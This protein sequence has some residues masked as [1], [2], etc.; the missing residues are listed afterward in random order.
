MRR[1]SAFTI[2]R[3]TSRCS[4]CACAPASPRPSSSMAI[5]DSSGAKLAAYRAVGTLYNALMTALV[6]GL[7]TRRGEETA[8]DYVFRHFRP[9]HLEKFLPGLQK[10]G[11]AAEPDAPASPLY[12]SHPN[13]L[14]APKPRHRPESDQ[15]PCAP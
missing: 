6:L 8:R 14:R 1:P 7:I 9:Q 4:T 5:P 2:R 12:H 3:T 15:H 13:A 11:L 10:L